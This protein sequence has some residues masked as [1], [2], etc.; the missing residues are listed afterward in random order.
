[1]TAKYPG[2]VLYLLEIVSSESVWD[3]EDISDGEYTKNQQDNENV[4]IKSAPQAPKQKVGLAKLDIKVEIDNRNDDVLLDEKCG[5]EYRFVKIGSENQNDDGS[6]QISTEHQPLVWMHETNIPD[7][8]ITDS[9]AENE[10][11]SKNMTS[12]Q[13]TDP[14]QETDVENFSFDVS[15]LSTNIDDYDSDSQIMDFRKKTRESVRLKWFTKQDIQDMEQLDSEASRSDCSTKNKNSKHRSKTSVRLRWIQKNQNKLAHIADVEE[16][17]C[18]A[19]DFKSSQTEEHSNS[20]TDKISKSKNQK[21]RNSVKIKWKSNHEKLTELPPSSICGFATED[22]EEILEEIS[23]RKSVRTAS[24]RHIRHE[25]FNT[26]NKSNMSKR[27][28]GLS[29][30]V[31]E[32]DVVEAVKDMISCTELTDNDLPKKLDEVFE[33]MKNSESDETEKNYISLKCSVSEADTKMM[34][35]SNFSKADD[36]YDEFFEEAKL[37]FIEKNKMPKNQNDEFK[38]EDSTVEPEVLSGKETESVH[39]STHSQRTPSVREKTT[40]HWRTDLFTSR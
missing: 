28:V 12:D 1:M 36:V 40:V 10:E 20:T 33:E 29:R 38:N 18:D 39:T 26:R 24:E 13:I 21:L 17:C 8:D 14:H 15:E 11:N 30:T 37:R 23:T 9:E 32:K 34:K 27:S 6:D 22:D 31:S 3:S 16:G 19:K 2:K 35:G 25:H 4:E 5:K 7:F